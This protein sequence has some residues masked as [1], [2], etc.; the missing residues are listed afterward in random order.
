M[1]LPI[2]CKG[3]QTA[4]YCSALN[5]IMYAMLLLPLPHFLQEL[6]RQL[7]AAEKD[8]V[9]LAQQL[10]AEQQGLADDAKKLDDTR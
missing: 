2:F 6:D 8:R 10:V 9:M 1:Q 3:Y 5:R 4:L 7:A